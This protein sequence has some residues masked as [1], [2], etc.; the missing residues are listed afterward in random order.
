MPR[1]SK[2]SAPPLDPELISNFHSFV[3]DGDVGEIMRQLASTPRLANAKDA[4]GFAPLMQVVSSKTMS[5]KTQVQL[6]DGIVEKG[7]SL[8]TRDPNGCHVLSLACKSGAA[9]EVIDCVLKWNSRRG[10]RSVGWH[11]CDADRNGAL[12]L[13][14]RSGSSNLVSHSLSLDESETFNESNDWVKVVTSAIESGDEQTVLHVL[15]N[16]EWQGNLACDYDEGYSKNKHV[17]MVEEA[18]NRNM[19]DAVREMSLLDINQMCKL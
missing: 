19:F 12:V 3:P 9:V 18:Y 11:H 7:A 13:A 16:E 17:E 5:S 15:R 4:F 8:S 6:I 1:R 10:G 14:A 2:Q